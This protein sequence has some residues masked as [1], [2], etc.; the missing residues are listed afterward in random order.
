VKLPSWF[1]NTSIGSRLGW[2]FAALV[3]LTLVYGGLTLRQM[4]DLEGQASL[5]FQHPFTV[6]RAVAEAELQVLKIHREMKDLANSLVSEEVPQYLARVDGYEQEALRQLD[7]ARDRFLGDREKVQRVHDALVAWRPIRQEVGWLRMQ[8]NFAAAD[9]ITRGRGAEHVA[10]LE[11]ELEALKTFAQGKAAESIAHSE[12]I[13]QEA[14]TSALL[15]LAGAALLGTVIALAITRSIRTPLGDLDRA[16]ARMGEGDLE[17]QV[18]V[19][20]RDELGRLSR[21]FNTMADSIRKK[22]EEIRRKN[23]E[24][25]RLLLNILPGPIADRLKQGEEPIA[26][27]FPDVTVLF[28]D[29]VGFTHL[30]TELPPSELV[31]ILDEIFTSFDEA[32][33]YLGIEKI[34]TIGDAYMAVSGLTHDLEDQVSSMVQMGLDMLEAVDRINQK[35]GTDFEVRIGINCGPVVAGVIGRSKFIYDLWGDAVNLASRMESHGI[36]GRIQVTEEVRTRIGDRFRVEERGEIEVKG[37]GI[38]RTYLI[39]DGGGP[40]G[41]R[42]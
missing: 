30:S 27:H 31:Q 12:A 35:R 7:I 39:A 23:E 32:A 33:A 24:N 21:T 28:A 10:L 26:D 18:P 41:E 34:K 8:G 36:S 25:E 9:A 40:R 42:S 22:T 19:H 4:R 29:I 3:G 1:L 20:G 11:R 17:Q 38:V 37:R 2:G 6:T 13:L 14:L 15:L 5:L 16:A